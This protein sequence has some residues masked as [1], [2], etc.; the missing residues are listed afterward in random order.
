MMLH[1]VLVGLYTLLATLPVICW[2]LP[3]PSS[4]SLSLSTSLSRTKRS[5]L[6]F[7]DGGYYG[8]QHPRNNYH[9]SNAYLSNRYT[10]IDDVMLRDPDVFSSLVKKSAR[11]RLLRNFRSGMYSENFAQVCTSLRLLEGISGK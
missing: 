11:S 10:R 7:D 8:Y 3:N 5:A 4:S 9:R 6:L 2:S 1:Q